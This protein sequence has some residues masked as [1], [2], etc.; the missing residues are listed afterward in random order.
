[1]GL[2]THEQYIVI[3]GQ[4]RRYKNIP[5]LNKSIKYLNASYPD[6]QVCLL[7]QPHPELNRDEIN[8]IYNHP[9]ILFSGSRIGDDDYSRLVRDSLFAL[10]TYDQIS[11][12]GSAIHALSQ[13]TKVVAP[14]I[15]TLQT[16][17]TSTMHGY[18][19]RNDDIESLRNAIDL[20][21]DAQREE[22][23]HVDIE[24]VKTADWTKMMTRI[25]A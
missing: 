3:P 13:G 23:A 11:T 9:N 22:I 10:L 12:S 1:L 2:C 15:G 19:Y 21:I 18:L 24:K 4:I 5:L 6:I 7:G 14:R 17:I 25:L 8:S 16:L 20:V